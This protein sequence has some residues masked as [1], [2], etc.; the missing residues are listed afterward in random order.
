M[1][2]GARVL[3][4]VTLD[5]GP[6]TIEVVGEDP[7][8]AVAFVAPDVELHATSEDGATY[9]GLVTGTDVIIVGD[10]PADASVYGGLARPTST[11]R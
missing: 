6:V 10:L 9:A 8:T 1:L 5:D 3:D 4:A 11:A 7:S 2:D